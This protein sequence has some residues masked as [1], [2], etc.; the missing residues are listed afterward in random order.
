MSKY[1]SHKVNEIS[2]QRMVWE[3]ECECGWVG[4]CVRNFCKNILN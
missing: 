1:K 3:F 2:Q 4:K